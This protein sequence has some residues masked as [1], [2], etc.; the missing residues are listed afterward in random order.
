MN[1][2]FF[3]SWEYLQSK[4]VLLILEFLILNKL[5]E[6]TSPRSEKKNETINNYSQNIC[7][8]QIQNT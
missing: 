4:I 7:I 3:C 5:K 1:F 8:K 2:F 6:N